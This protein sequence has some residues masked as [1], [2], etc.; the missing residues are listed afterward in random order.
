MPNYIA[1]TWEKEKRMNV[2]SA[3]VSGKKLTVEHSV[4]LASPSELAGFVKKNHLAKTE[5]VAVLDRSDVEVRP[6]IFPPVPVEEI[7]SL[8][9]FQAGKEFNHYSASDL[10]DFFVTNR[11]DN[12]SR[13]TFFP[14]LR[15]SAGNAAASGSPR[16]VMAS[17]L[18]Q[19]EFGAIR[20]FCYKADLN[21]RSVVLRPC[22]TVFLWRNSPDYDASLPILL[23]ELDAEHTSQ[24]AVLQGEPVFMRSPRIICPEDVSNPEFAAR[25]IAELKRSRAAV[26][27]EVQGITVEAAVLCGKGSQYESLARQVSAGLEMPVRL[28]DAQHI[29]AQQTETLPERFLPLLGAVSRIAKREAYP[30]DFCRPKKRKEPA[31][32][33]NLMTGIIAAVILFAVAF[34]VYGVYSRMTLQDEVRNLSRE[35]NELKTTAGTV[36]EERTQVDAVE[37]WLGDK[38]NWFEQLGWLSKQAPKA[39]NMMVNELT[40]SAQSGGGM[41][42]KAQLLDGTVLSAMESGFRDDKHTVKTGER[43]DIP[44]SGDNRY[45]FR[46]TVSI[47]LTK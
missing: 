2:L 39:E 31:S 1:F 22:E 25:L 27:N 42:F 36:V 29:A 40:C 21:L 41:S 33:R 37:A 11:F 24:T 15:P 7:P 4:T 38:V 19:D 16:F 47:G 8:V 26:R 46:C 9:Q 13:S 18:R 23:V 5:A 17:A 3:S 12:V 6:M 20:L 32:Q 43:G 14:A 44:V 28:F 34:L 45:R 30:I 10:L 35:F